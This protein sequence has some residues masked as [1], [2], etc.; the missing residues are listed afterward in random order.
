MKILSTNKKHVVAYRNVLPAD[1]N[2]NTA[3]H[4]PVASTSSTQWTQCDMLTPADTNNNTATHCPVASTSSTQWTQC[5]MLTPADTNNN[6]ATHCPV[7]STCSTQWTQC[8]MLTPAVCHT[9]I[10]VQARP[11]PRVLLNT[12]E[13]APNGVISQGNSLHSAEQMATY[14]PVARRTFGMYSSNCVFQLGSHNSDCLQ[15]S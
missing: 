2:N 14:N 1:T 12:T 11:T 3:T 8:D 13:A 7:A 4:C 15:V 9:L 10:S 6:T 5:D